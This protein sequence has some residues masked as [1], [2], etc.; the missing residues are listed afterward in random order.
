MRLLSHEITGDRVVMVNGFQIILVNDQREHPS[1]SPQ[2]MSVRLSR[3]LNLCNRHRSVG[4]CVPET[5]LGRS[6]GAS[7][8]ETQ[9]V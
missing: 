1:S 2:Y 5:R 6:V 3:K 8:P 7:V 9:L 4:A